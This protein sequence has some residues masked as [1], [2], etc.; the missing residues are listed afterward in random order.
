MHVRDGAGPQR[1]QRRFAAE[2]A[3]FTAAGAFLHL[4]MLFQNLDLDER[5]APAAAG[6]QASGRIELVQRPA[7]MAYECLIPFRSSLLL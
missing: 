6:V 5:I 4:S 7:V 2:P 3:P 1:S